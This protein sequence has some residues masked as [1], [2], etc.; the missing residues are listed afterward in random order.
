MR[1]A[2]LTSIYPAH[3][4]KIYKENLTLKNQTSEQ[5]MEYIRW[6]AL[7][8]Y[9]RWFELLEEKG[10]ITCLF[11]HNLPEVALTW[12]RENKFQ[13]K[14]SNPI[15][16]IG[17]EKIRQFKP[18]VIFLFAPLTYLKNNFLNELLIKLSKRP[19][20]IAWYG[21]NCGNEDIFRS[22]D[23]TLSNSKH[24]VNSLRKRDIKADFLQH[25]FDPI[26]IEK[27]KIP[28]ERLNRVAFFGNLD[29]TTNDFRERTRLFEEISNRT[30]LLDVY[31][32]HKT[33][34]SVEISKNKLLR[35]RQRVS[36][37]INQFV[38]NQKFTYWSDEKNLPQSPWLLSRNFCSRI[39]PSLYGKEML[40]QLSSYHIALNYH[41]K[42]TGDFACNMRLFEATG[43]G[44]A[45]ITD[46][47]SDLNEYFEN[48]KE[49][50][51]FKNEEDLLEKIKYLKNNVS[52]TKTIGIQAQKKCLIQFN[53][54]NQLSILKNFL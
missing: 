32:E 51:S 25:A 48:D 38:T 39:K 18:D 13:P 10:F 19:K 36:S 4:E 27:I 1:I 11:N 30:N 35:I 54:K 29:V 31:G 12:A 44:C 37:C 6:H 47:K 42:H 40:Q 50:V 34:S 23:L 45:L 52:V 22:F 17:L 2:F 43:V 28:K 15:N 26:I 46:F 9:V 7:S 14:T 49:V 21:A 3:A 33:P 20:L 53:T 8:S 41:N 16:E 24:L 5:Q